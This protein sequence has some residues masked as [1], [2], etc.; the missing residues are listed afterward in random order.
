MPESQRKNTIDDRLR[1]GHA[2]ATTVVIADEIERLVEEHADKPWAEVCQILN[3][4][5]QELRHPKRD[6][7]M[8][9]GRRQR[10]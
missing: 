6:G 3:E 2:T 4:R 8:D 10:R 7:D 5:R 1:R 9:N